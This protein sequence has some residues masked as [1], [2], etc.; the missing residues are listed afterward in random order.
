MIRIMIIDG[1]V[2]GHGEPDGE[3][4][5]QAMTKRTYE[6]LVGLGFVPD[7]WMNV[8][9][10]FGGGNDGRGRQFEGSLSTRFLSL[11]KSAL[12]SIEGKSNNLAALKARAIAKLSPDEQRVLGLLK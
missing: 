11:S 6:A 12:A 3:Q 7:G 9:C 2:D 4:P 8:D 1:Y 5:D 10:R